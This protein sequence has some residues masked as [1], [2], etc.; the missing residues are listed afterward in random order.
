MLAA[1]IVKGGTFKAETFNEVASSP[2][3]I[4]KG[5]T[6]GIIETHELIETGTDTNFSIKN[7]GSITAKEFI[8]M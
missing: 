1:S 2:F 7:D 4:K 3:K 5:T 8:E 6:A